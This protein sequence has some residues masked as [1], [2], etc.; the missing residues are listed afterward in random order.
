MKVQIVGMAW[1]RR[2]TFDAL[3]SMFEDGDK[4]HRTYDEWLAASEKG[5]KQLEG[6]G[7]TIKCVDIDPVEF[8]AWCHA[9]GLKLNAES[10]IAFCNE[11]AFKA[12]SQ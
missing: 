8:P 5:R 9:K 3:R 7:H 11:S 6:K 10:R 4:L 1:Y 12:V 2:E